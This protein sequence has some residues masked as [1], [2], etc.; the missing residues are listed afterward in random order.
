MQSGKPIDGERKEERIRPKQRELHVHVQLC[1]VHKNG[2]IRDCIRLAVGAVVFGSLEI[3]Y[4]DPKS[5]MCVCGA[6]HHLE[7]EPLPKILQNI[8]INNNYN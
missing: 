3:I 7:F 1:I 6:R 8:V 2:K 4:S 5:C